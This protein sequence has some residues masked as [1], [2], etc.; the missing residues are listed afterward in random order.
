[1][2]K[3]KKIPT[4]FWEYRNRQ[5]DDVNLADY[6]LEVGGAVERP[7]IASLR[8]LAERVP[9]VEMRRRFYCVNGWSLEALWSG[10]RVADLMA[11]VVPRAG[12]DYLRVTSVGGYDDTSPIQRLIE[13]DALLATHMDGEPLSVERGKPMRMILFDMYQFKGVKAVQRIEVVADYR[14]GFWE[15]VGYSEEM[16]EIQPYPHFA[17]DLGEERMPELDK[18]ANAEPIERSAR[19]RRKQS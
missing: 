3:P 10:Y 2:S 16:I 15:T 4:F 7:F 19:V 14:P 11:A 8:E 12:F 18:L 13:G 9:R 1:M 5:P 6:R 17:I